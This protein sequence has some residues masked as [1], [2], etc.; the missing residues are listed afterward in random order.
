MT[1]H[2]SSLSYWF[3]TVCSRY[4]RHSGGPET[5]LRT[6]LRMHGSLEL[7]HGQETPF[8]LSLKMAEVHQAD[9]LPRKRFRHWGMRD[10]HGYRPRL[11]KN[12]VLQNPVQRLKSPVLSLTTT[13][14]VTF[15]ACSS[16]SYELAFAH[17]RIR[18]AKAHLSNRKS[19]TRA[20]GAPR[21]QDQLGAGAD[22]PCFV[23][24]RPRRRPGHC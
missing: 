17:V 19:G 1:R 6:S 11:L 15:A 20:L 21:R 10:T 2:K 4:P 23:N 8:W 7:K 18:Y 5:F 9:P 13:S 16:I 3:V 14:I 22:A 24:R 12:G